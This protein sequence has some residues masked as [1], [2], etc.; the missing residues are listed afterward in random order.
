MKKTTSKL[1][2]VLVSLL[3]PMALMGAVFALCGLAPF[4]DRSLG[5]L[6]MSS[7]YLSFL[8]FLRQLLS[9]QASFL[10][11]PGLALG[12]NMAGV[13]AYYLMSPLNLL[14]CLFSRENLLTAV[15]L[16]YILRV[17]LA[18]MTMALYAG[19]RHGW[20]W[21]VLGP[22]L[23][24]GFMAFLTA[25]SINY[26]WQDG[27]ILLPV[28]A[29]GIARLTEGR[30]WRLYA[31]SLGAALILN[32]YIGYM[33]CLAAALFFL[34]SLL[35]GPAGRRGRR[36]LTFALTSLLAGALAAVVL[37]PTALVLMG[38]KAAPAD[39][40]LTGKFSFPAL[41]AKLLVGSFN[42][43]ELTPV[44][45]PNIFCGT[46]TAAFAALYFADGRL[47]RKRRLATACLLG[48]FTLSFWVSAL[49][50]IWHGLN[51]PA[52]YNYRYS[53]LFSFVV[54][55]AAD[56][57]LSLGPADYGPRQL[58]WPLAASVAVA[59]LALLGPG[60]DLVSWQ[61]GA[62]AVAATAGLCG[63]LYV[64]GRPGG[65]KRLA[66]GL[67]AA[68]LV[69]HMADLGANAKLSFD[70]LTAI[71]SDPA[72][73]AAYSVE[74]AAALDLIDTGDAYVRV[75]SPELFD[76]NRCE[77]MLFGYDGLSHY[78][79]TLPLKNL[80]FLRRLGVPVYK[81]LFTLYGPDVTA[82]ADSLLGV[83]YLA[84][85]DTQKPYTLL[86]GD[87]A[88]AAYENPYALPVGWTADGTFAEPVDAEDPFSYTQALYDA[89][90]PEVG[91][92]IY[93][94]AEAPAPVTEGIVDNGGGNYT[95][96]A[97]APSGNLIYT[98]D[99]KADGPLYG[100]VDIVGWPGVMVFVDGAYAAYYATGQTN[101]TLYLGQFAAGDRVEVRIQAATDLTVNGAAF[102]TEHAEA[103][104]AYRDALADGGCPLTKLSDAH[105]TGSFTAGQG[106]ELL[107]L[108]IPADP[109][110]RIALDGEKIEAA[111]VQDCLTALAVSPGGHTLDM[112][113][114]P[115]GLIP[116]GIVS[117]AA[118][119]LVAAL[120]LP[121]RAR[122]RS[123]EKA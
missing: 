23:A 8:G 108:T 28:I 75:E 93:T 18:S 66:A 21:R 32:F 59:A 41:F 43:D 47:P 7:Q 102:A 77:S 89:A 110:W 67:G 91:E 73:W 45:L 62:W 37:V 90:A 104:A 55:A 80:E 99:V 119:V 84:A 29:L 83:K 50:L 2:I 35:T 68:V 20:S 79:S 95:L 39:L 19:E 121:G 3:L 98:V 56:R 1:P 11:L 120:S 60:R 114:V 5:V 30:G 36:V 12:G 46:I 15:S 49:D 38:G 33:L 54:I 14:C 78:G 53:F 34:Y 101:G 71:S 27:V 82:G 123:G 6:D 85:A 105:F 107:V 51:V 100:F 64:L 13:L 97:D 87:G 57:T 26:Q 10:Y 25:Y 92:D 4:G 115:P 86:G 44:G 58:L 81:E 111:E 94:F 9:G 70:Q 96:S 116:G 16:L 17:G 103:L 63:G 52:W 69:L 48:F 109:G 122:R 112:R 117:T 31:L 106:D 76:Q 40:T 74:K 118:L 61:A 113:Y 88:Y 72:K 42:Y 65:S 22:G 24:Y